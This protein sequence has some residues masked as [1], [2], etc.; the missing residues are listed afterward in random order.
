M[1]AKVTFMDLSGLSV[2]PDQRERLVLHILCI[3]Y[4][5]FLDHLER[6]SVNNPQVDTLERHGCFL[7][8]DT[9]IG[10]IYSGACSSGTGRLKRANNSNFRLFQL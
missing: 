9:R 7:A 1:P 3:K 8:A 5:N 4:L 10:I 6:N 2:V